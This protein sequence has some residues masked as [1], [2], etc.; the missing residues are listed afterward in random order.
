MDLKQTGKF[1]QEMRKKKN[2]TQVQ[3]AIKLGVSE[4]TVSKWECGNGFPDTTLMLPLCKVLEITAN[5]LL[6]AKCLSSEKEYVEKAENNIMLLKSQQEKNYKISLWVELVLIWL[7]VTVML[8]SVIVASYVD[9]STI[10]RVLLIIFGVLNMSVGFVVSMIIETKVGYYECGKCQHKYV[11][12]Y[13]Q[14]VWS[15]HMGRT[16]YMKCPKCK[17]HSWQR[18]TI[19][20]D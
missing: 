11:P 16:R 1:I 7:S 4:K 19:N 2:L 8:G 13:K 17:K 14:T 5:E 15:M 10:W 18:K 3:L 20:S 9:M 6:S 12:S